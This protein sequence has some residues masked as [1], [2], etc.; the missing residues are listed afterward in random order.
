MRTTQ[1]RNHRISKLTGKPIVGRSSH[2]L[3]LEVNLMC[4]RNQDLG[5]T[6]SSVHDNMRSAK[7]LKN[8]AVL[9][10][11]TDLNPMMHNR[12]RWSGK[13]YMLRRFLNIR[14]ELLEIHDSLDGDIEID[15]TTR[16]HG[17]LINYTKV[18]RAID[19]VTKSLQRKHHTLSECRDDLDV[20]VEAVNEENHNVS[21]DLYQCKLG[22]K[23][24]H[25]AI[26][27]FRGRNR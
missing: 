2:K 1:A 17:K 15:D 18:L 3:N 23:Y 7:T 14:E 8:V 13:L 21:S 26:S 24:R 5:N 16:F 12:T 11:L 27:A 6:I 10:N 9:R 22:Q 4:D 25:S 20:L 19:N